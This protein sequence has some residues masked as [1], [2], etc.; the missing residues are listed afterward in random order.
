M[1]GIIL[2]CRFY[3]LEGHSEMSIEIFPV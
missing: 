2:D 1:S 3:G